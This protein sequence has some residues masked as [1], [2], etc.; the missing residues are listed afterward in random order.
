MAMLEYL[1]G[2]ERRLR[3]GE[4]R[5]ESR[6]TRALIA[7]VS[8][9][10]TAPELT[11]L[12]FGIM[13]I[14]GALDLSAYEP[15]DRLHLCKRIRQERLDLLAAIPEDCRTRELAR[16]IQE[17]LRALGEPRRRRG[18]S[19]TFVKDVQMTAAGMAKAK[20]RDILRFLGLHP[21]RSGWGD[22]RE[23]RRNR[24]VDASRVFGEFAKENL[25]R[26]RR[27]IQRISPGD[28]ERPV[29]SVVT[30]MSEKPDVPPREIVDLVM[31]F[32]DRGFASPDFR[33]AAAYALVRAG[34]A[35]DG[36]DDPVCEM[37]AGWL[38]DYTPPDQVSRRGSDTEA[39][40]KREPH[41]LL[42]DDRGIRSLSGGNYPILRCLEV[43]FI[44][45]KPPAADAWLT[46][47]EKHLGR[48]ENPEVWDML[49]DELRFLWHADRDRTV[50]FFESLFDVKP[51]LRT[52]VEGLRLLA[53]THRWL[54]SDLV[55]RRLMGLME[56]EWDLGH[57]AAGELAGLRA[58]LV[59]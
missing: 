15:K 11:K 7:A 16:H 38:S 21:D 30:A 52:G 10:L 26:A 22:P 33:H 42:W 17:E 3:L 31:A 56:N 14:T 36:L 54:P 1:L 39:K 13:Q 12:A 43:G 55:N 34:S 28:I 49:A 46:V 23:L 48:T 44:R 27:L 53:W 45:R 24:S 58:I 40:K 6:A 35:I 59:P 41:P 32:H 25:G 57:Q 18:T 4:L 5:D 20:D 8:P 50:A 19:V 9:S 47:L 2:D 29:A 51:S 37:L